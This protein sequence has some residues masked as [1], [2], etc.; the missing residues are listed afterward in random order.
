MITWE[1]YLEESLNKIYYKKQELV[2]NQNKTEKEWKSRKK[3]YNKD[4][5]DPLY[6]IQGIILLT[7]I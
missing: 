7:N 3:A 2:W 6:L 5:K 1:E 4:N